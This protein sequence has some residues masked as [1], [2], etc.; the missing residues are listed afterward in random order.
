MRISKEILR[1]LLQFGIFNVVGQCDHVQ[2]KNFA[3]CGKLNDRQPAEQK[4]TNE[5]KKKKNSK[6]VQNRQSTSTENIGNT[7]GI[8]RKQTT[9]FRCGCRGLTSEAPKPSPFFSDYSKSCTFYAVT[10]MER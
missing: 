6:A 4:Q 2:D 9:C 8:V 3:P 5:V 7:V 10:K 1:K